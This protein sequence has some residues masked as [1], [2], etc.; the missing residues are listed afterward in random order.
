M[1]RQYVSMAVAAALAFS[2][3]AHAQP[4]AAGSP[5]LSVRANRKDKNSGKGGRG[6][7]PGNNGGKGFPHQGP[8]E[9]SKRKRNVARGLAHPGTVRLA[10]QRLAR[11]A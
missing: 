6:G 2:A 1:Q 8:A 10:H 9:C 11:A 5:N 4:A 7:R 3:F